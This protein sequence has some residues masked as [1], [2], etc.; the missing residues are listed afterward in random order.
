MVVARWQAEM[1]KVVAESSER[2]GGVHLRLLGK[3][4]LKNHMEDIPM[5]AKEKIYKHTVWTRSTLNQFKA[6]ECLE[7]IHQRMT[8]CS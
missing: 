3:R 1:Q 4:I 2:V 7:K 8:W 6:G 5:G